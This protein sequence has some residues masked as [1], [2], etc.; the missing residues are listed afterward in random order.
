MSNSG[1]SQSVQQ[2]EGVDQSEET[3]PNASIESPFTVASSTTNS[4][5][6]DKEDTVVICHLENNRVKIYIC[7]YTSF[8]KH[9]SKFLSDDDNC[10]K[11][12]YL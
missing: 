9:L 7:S 6:A 4:S 8:K 10:I 1:S 11:R 12:N 2:Q 5:F 3:K